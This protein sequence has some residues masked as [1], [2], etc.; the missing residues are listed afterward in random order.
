MDAEM[1]RDQALSISGLLVKD[2]GGKSVKPYQ[3]AGLWKPVGFGQQHAT[4]ARQWF[5]S[6]QKK[7]VHILEKDLP[8]PSMAIF[9]APN[10]ETC[11]VR[12][13]RTNTPLQA[14]VL[15]NDVQFFEA[16]REF[17]EKIMKDGGKELNEKLSYAYEQYS[18]GVQPKPSPTHSLI[19]N[20]HLSEFPKTMK[21][22]R[23]FL[24]VENQLLT[25]PLIK[26]NSCGP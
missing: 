20:E 7:H 23:K 19:Y 5:S 18:E 13:A 16:A 21:Q 6:L 15:M 25:H 10:R 1:I 17:A 26:L 12:R 2:I 3:P 24:K 9:D 14:L 11:T 8:P 4:Q 22:Q